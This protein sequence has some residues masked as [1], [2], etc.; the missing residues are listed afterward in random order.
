MPRL[1]RVF[2]TCWFTIFCLKHRTRIL[3]SVPHFLNILVSTCLCM[4]DTFSCFAVVRWF[5]KVNLFQKY[6]QSV[7]HFESR[8]T[9]TAGQIARMRRMVCAFVVVFCVQKSQGFSRQCPH[10]FLCI[11]K[12]R[13]AS[14]ETAVITCENNKG[15]GVTVQSHQRV[16]WKLLLM[17]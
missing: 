9:Q 11:N 1:I 13:P 4:L 8:S 16:K 7:K 5:Y 2:S 15:L 12:I 14:R 6:H 17:K 3:N 10:L